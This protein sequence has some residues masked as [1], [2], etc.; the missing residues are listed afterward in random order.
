MYFYLKYVP[1]KKKLVE[2]SMFYELR[3]NLFPCRQITEAPF[4]ANGLPQY[5]SKH[6]LK[7]AQ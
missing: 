3:T 6:I 1:L 5:L 4:G 7:L 2:T